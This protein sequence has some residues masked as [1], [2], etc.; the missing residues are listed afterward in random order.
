MTN[1]FLVGSFKGYMFISSLKN[2]FC[3]ELSMTIQKI[4]EINK[5]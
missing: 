4:N 2:F 1:S 3:E 5:N